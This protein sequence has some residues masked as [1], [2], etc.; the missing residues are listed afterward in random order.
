MKELTQERLKQLM[1]YDP[2][3]GVFTALV[4]RGS[5]VRVGDVVGGINKQKGYIQMWVGGKIYRGHTLA[6]LYMTGDFPIYEVD[7]IN[8]I[9]YDNRW[10]NLR[11][12][13]H[14]VNMNNRKDNLNGRVGSKHIAK[15]KWSVTTPEGKVI[16]LTSLYKFCNKHNL[17]YRTMCRIGNKKSKK[18]NY[19]GYKCCALFKN[20]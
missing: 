4:D 18:D 20:N 13:P 16:I 10:N 11:D 19:K 15:T 5:R 3:T 9:K 14:I 6:V 17:P 1:S 8:Q 2:D 12:V 7:H